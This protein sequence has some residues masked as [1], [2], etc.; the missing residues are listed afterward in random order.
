MS[1]LNIKK[2]IYESLTFHFVYDILHLHSKEVKKVIIV[3]NLEDL[4]KILGSEN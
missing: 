3:E 4:I 1:M 2:V